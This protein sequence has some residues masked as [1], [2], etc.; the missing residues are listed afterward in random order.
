MVDV[1]LDAEQMSREDAAARLEE[2]AQE[3]RE[4]DAF[5]VK[6]GNKTVTLNPR[7]KI[8]F[9]LSVRERSAILRGNRET[10]SIKMDW[11]PK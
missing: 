6:V 8:A 7:E 2:L 10:V 1:T 9:E 3:L 11:K 4:G 5:D